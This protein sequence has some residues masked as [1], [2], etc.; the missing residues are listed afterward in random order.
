MRFEFDEDLLELSAKIKV[1]GVGGGGN[2]AVNRMIDIGIR[3]VEFMA[4]NTDAQDLLSSKAPVKMQIGRQLTSGLGAGADPEVGRKAALESEEQLS[5]AIAGAHMVFITAG[6]GGGT[7]TGAAPVIAELARKQGSLTVAVVT[8][9]FMFEGRTRRQQAEIGYRALQDAVDTVITVPNERLLQ[10]V[11][12][13][14][15]LIDAFKY[16]DDVL[17]Q[18]VQSIAE[19][20]TVPGII[21]LD[22]ADIKTVMSEMGGALMGTGTASG[23]Q[24]ALKAARE[25]ITSPLL[26]D[27]NIAG[28]RGL[29][30]NITGGKTLTLHEVSEASDAIFEC[31]GKE[32]NVIFGAVVDEDMNDEV[33]I[34]VIAT[35]FELKNR[36]Q[37]K[38]VLRY[39][40]GARAM[41]LQSYLKGR[42]M[43]RRNTGPEGPVHDQEG[44]EMD[45]DIPTFLRRKVEAR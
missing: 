20:I 14:T 24:R 12:Q 13:Q 2:N 40:G 19:L 27:I 35:G 37:E 9:P 1:V 18:A 45:L 29:L 44:N 33:K 21:N 30:I 17:R 11:S 41:D 32:A 8:R 34:T 36:E 25:A 16:A 5:A 15:T 3:G 23:E 10:V 7:G 26:E 43:Q 22:F 31:A 39:R 6:L 42:D 4:V 38:E 28:A